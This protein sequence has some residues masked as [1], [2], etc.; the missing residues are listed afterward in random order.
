MLFEADWQLLLKWH[1]SYGF[2]PNSKAAGTLTSAQGG[3]RKGRSTID[4]ATQQIIETELIKLSQKPAIDLFLDARWCFDLMV[5]A[6]HNMVC[7]RQGDADD[8]LRLHAQTH[9]TMKYYVRHKYGVLEDFN[10]FEQHP[11][12]GAG[13]G[14]ADAALRYIALLDSLIDA[15]HSKIQPWVIKDP[16]L[17]IVIVKSMKAFIDNVA[18]SISGDASTTEQLIQRAQTQLQWW[19]QLIQ[20]SGGALNPQKCCCA[21]YTWA[22]DTSGIILRFSTDDPRNIQITPCIQQPEKHI[23]VLKPNEGTHYLGIYVTR[24]GST[25]PMQDQIWSKAILYTKAFQRTH[26]SRREASVLYRACF[27]P[28]L[29]YSLPAMHLP[30]TFLEQLHKLSTLTILNKM[31]YHRKLP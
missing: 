29:T 3:G 25:Q 4:Q 20:A 28:A 6:C 11:W 16:T 12:H 13:Q 8:Y 7:R 15:Y 21:L 24:T 30:D 22:L 26:M 9:R 17:T 1:S 27:L 23:Q 14:A 19:T 5:E 18:M 31:G 2:L 10:T